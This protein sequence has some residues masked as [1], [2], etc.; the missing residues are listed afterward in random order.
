MTADI[1]ALADTVRACFTRAQSLGP[2]DMSDG[3]R[4]LSDLVAIAKEEAD[5]C[6]MCAQYLDDAGA[7]DLD[8]RKA[9]ID[10]LARRVRGSLSS[11][12]AHR[13]EAALTLLVA[14]AKEAE[15]WRD[16]A[17][18]ELGTPGL[19]RMHV[20]I[21][22]EAHGEAVEDAEAAEADN[23]AMQQEA[24]E[25]EAELAEANGERSLATVRAEAAEERVVALEGALMHIGRSD[26]WEGRTH[27]VE[28]WA[29]MSWAAA[30]ARAAVG[31]REPIILPDTKEGAA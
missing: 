14:T 5:G 2:T 23:R 11:F 21:L 15:E 18:P 17:P 7:S 10:A 27:V 24:D 30:Y 12:Q 13:V 4:S 25:L 20:E 6:D 31:V 19:F 8:A 3:H 9:R 28:D 29:S 26:Y 16:I 1:D 22:E